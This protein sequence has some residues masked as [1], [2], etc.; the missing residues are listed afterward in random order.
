MY[1]VFRLA[2]Q[3]W[4]QRRAPRMSLTDTHVSHHLCWPWDLDGFAE[5]NN[6]RTLT[7]YDLGRFGAGARTGLMEVLRTRRW[8]LAVAGASVRYRKRVTAF[9]RIEMRTRCVGWDARF[10][11][12]LQSMWV[13]G[14]C[15]SE[16][17]LRTAV[18]SPAGTL[19]PAQVVEAL[20]WRGAAPDLPGWVAAWV[21]A[22]ARRP[23]PPED[24]LSV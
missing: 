18:T 24:A 21:A 8:G 17:L 23:W 6:G 15:T 3:I 2:L 4:R 22:E 14:V 5:L 10:V 16:A 13:K 9:Q 20:G 12:I 7:L 1:P 19:P 11:Y